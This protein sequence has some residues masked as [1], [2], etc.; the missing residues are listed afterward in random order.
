MRGP[1]LLAALLV[2]G[3][4]RAR[5]A[6]GLGTSGATFLRL[7]QGAR[8][9]GM[10]G[11]FVAVAD[12]GNSLWW[13]PAGLAR[14]SYKEIAA[15]HVKYFDNITS[16]FGA[17]VLPLS[18]TL[19]TLGAS[20]T[21]LNIPGLDAFTAAGATAGRITANGFSGGLGYGRKILPQLSVGVNLKIVGQTLHTQQTRGFASDLGIQFRQSGIGVGFCVQNLGPEIKLD[22]GGSEPLPQTLRGGISYSPNGRLTFAVDEEK[23]SDGEL[24]FHAGTEFKASP[25][26]T[27][28]GGYEQMKSQGGGAGF[29]MGISYTTMLGAGAGGG[30]AAEDT[31]WWDKRLDDIEKPTKPEGAYL[32]F[33]DYAF[34]TMGTLTDAHRF[35]IGVKF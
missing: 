25:A 19:G 15:G 35:T 4:A 12:D 28:R 10:G 1:A 31:P 5:A 3:P 27:I 11:A 33:A 6:A 21:Y 34:I 7:E 23:A 20:F 26:F 13:N 8:P 24:K 18:P 32:V 22:A 30:W 2:L 17:I 9:V 16:E 29:A 14:A